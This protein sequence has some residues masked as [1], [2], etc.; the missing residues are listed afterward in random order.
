MSNPPLKNIIKKVWVWTIKIWPIMGFWAH[1]L[2]N[3]LLSSS[4]IGG[5]DRSPLKHET[6]SPLLFLLI[7]S[8]YKD[9]L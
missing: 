7:I 5:L 2:T 8:V 3:L 9:G 1:D 6:L 4:Q